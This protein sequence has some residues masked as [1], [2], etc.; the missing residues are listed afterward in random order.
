MRI[1]QLARQTGL[2]IHALRYYERRGLLP[3]VPRGPSNYR[4]FSPRSVE[5]VSFI[6]EAKR[7]GFTLAEIR[8]LLD[9]QTSAISCEVLRARAERKV[10]EIEDRIRRLRMIKSTVTTLL[11]NCN[12]RKPTN[13][14]PVV[15]SLRSLKL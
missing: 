11:R 15:R 10:A 7:L 1:G 5:R 9:L 6:R 4:E 12:A 13:S 14:C 3:C 8:E 2:S